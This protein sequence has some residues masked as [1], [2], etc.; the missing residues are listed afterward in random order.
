[1]N[2][3]N[4]N[5]DGKPSTN[6]PLPNSIS[7]LSNSELIDLINLQRDNL[8]NY[9]TQFN[10]QSDYKDSIEKLLEELHTLEIK[11]NELESKKNDTYENLES[12]Q[13]LES[14]YVKEWQDLNRHIEMNYSSAAIKKI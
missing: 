10:L 1:M 4:L 6:I 8:A 14:Q 5:E 9:V 7:I 13:I 11:F 2:L 3:P 12:C